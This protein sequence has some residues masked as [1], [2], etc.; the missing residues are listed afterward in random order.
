VPAA[1]E[2]YPDLL[3]AL[4]VG[5][6]VPAATPKPVIEKIAQANRRVIS[7]DEFKKRLYASGFEP[8][9]DTP[10]EAERF[11]QAERDR[12]LPLVKAVG[13]KR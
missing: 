10:Q 5:V 2:T 11:V 9:L 13:F 3:A 7:S 8:I 12:I 1:V 4:F 6:F